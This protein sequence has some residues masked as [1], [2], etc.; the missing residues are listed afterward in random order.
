MC[1]MPFVPNQHA[2]MAGCKAFDKL[3]GYPQF[4]FPLLKVEFFLCLRNL[5][6]IYPYIPHTIFQTPFYNDP[7]PLHPAV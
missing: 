2:L 4:Q 3:E 1:L 5:W 7:E 6:R